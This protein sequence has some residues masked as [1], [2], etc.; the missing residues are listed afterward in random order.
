[1]IV[2]LNEKYGAGSKLFI[3]ILDIFKQ[4][5]Y[6]ILHEPHPKVKELINETLE[7]LNK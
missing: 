7:K 6:K 5:P 2:Y 1:M 3:D 4:N